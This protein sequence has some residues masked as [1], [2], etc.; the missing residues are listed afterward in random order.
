MEDAFLLFPG[1]FPFSS[2]GFLAFAGNGPGRVELRPH[3]KGNGAVRQL[4]VPPDLRH[5][6]VR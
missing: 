3:R 4:D 6:L 2:L 5:L 1:G